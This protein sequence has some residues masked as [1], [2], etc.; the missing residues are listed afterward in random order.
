MHLP[1]PIFESH[2]QLVTLYYDILDLTNDG[3]FAS[4]HELLIH[5]NFRP[6][7]FRQKEI[8]K[9]LESPDA[10]EWGWTNDIWQRVWIEV[11]PK[12][13]GR[14]NEYKLVGITEMVKRS[15]ICGSRKVQSLD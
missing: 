14:P 12:P 11:I 13:D 6:K 10:W 5:P 15:D 3:G 1:E 9:T 4:V 8:W 7:N 2:S